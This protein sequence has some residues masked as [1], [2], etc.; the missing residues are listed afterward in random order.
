MTDIELGK[1][2]S[3]I[4]RHHPESIGLKL[5]KEGY[6]FVDELIKKINNSDKY[7]GELNT[8]R[9]QRIVDTNDK[10]RYSYNKDKTKIR[11]VQGHSFHVDVAK[12]SIPPTSLFHGTSAD[13]YQSIKKKGICKMTRDYVHLSK[14]M[15]T[16]KSVGLRH[17]KKEKDLV[18][19]KIDSKSMFAD[20]YKFLV[21]ENG[22][23]LCE[24]I[25]PKYILKI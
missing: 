21:A 25:P 9:L 18:V 5:D 13:A 23:W 2:I 6:A 1:Y 14:D 22:V 16:A 10:K 19:L 3:Y 4:L 15:Q 11:A 8:E 17:A 24:H 20:G 12:V 7:H